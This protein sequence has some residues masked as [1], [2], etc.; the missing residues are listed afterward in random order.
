MM[1]WPTDRGRQGLFDENGANDR[2]VTVTVYPIGQASLVSDR[3][4]C[5]TAFMSG[6]AL[7]RRACACA[8][9]FIYLKQ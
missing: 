1:S 3:L 6:F 5:Q 2:H 7:H 9:N 4:L 8:L